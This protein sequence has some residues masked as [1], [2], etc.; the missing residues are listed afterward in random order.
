MA[1]QVVAE[2]ALSRTAGR[3]QLDRLAADL[4]AEFPDVKSLDDKIV[5]I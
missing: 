4:N 5:N 3:R 2:L 1:Q